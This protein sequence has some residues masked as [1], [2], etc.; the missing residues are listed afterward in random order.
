MSRA[1]E[2]VRHHRWGGHGASVLGAALLALVTMLA[3]AAPWLVPSRPWDT[4][5]DPAAPPDARFPLGT[6]V[7]GQDLFS[8]LLYGARTSLMIGFLV[9]GLSTALSA[10]VGVTAGLWP[11]GRAAIMALVDLFLAIPSVPLVVLLAVF[12]GSGFW[13]LVVVLVLVGWAAFARIVQ[14]QVQV[15]IRKDY[16][17]AARALGARSGRVIRTSILPEV[18]PVLSTKFL[19]TVRWAVLME[20]TLGLLGLGDPG[21]VSW[22]LMLHQAFSYPLLFITDAWIWWAAPPA[23][24]I[25]AT[26]L[27]LMAIGRDLDLWLNPASRLPS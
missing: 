27:G 7:L 23:L 12:L 16:V 13:S 22:G 6:N 21:R 25:V 1:R 11:R 19:L 17:E 14:A 20:A 9:A 15:T 24:A 26:S 4:V 2:A 18:A 5:G 3:L 8:L 10:A